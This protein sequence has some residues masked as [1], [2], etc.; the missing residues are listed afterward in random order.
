MTPR[1]SVQMEF[2]TL[3]EWTTFFLVLIYYLLTHSLTHYN[4]PTC[5]LSN[6]ARRVRTPFTQV[7]KM[8][9]LQLV[10]MSASLRQGKSSV[11][12]SMSAA[13]TGADTGNGNG[14][15]SLSSSGWAISAAAAGSGEARAAK[16]IGVIVL[17]FVVSWLPLYTINTRCAAPTSSRH[18]EP[19]VPAALSLCSRYE[20]GVAST[21]TC[22][23][24]CLSFG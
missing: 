22:P 14:G 19:R 11:T 3:T 13:A 8:S 21:S 10:P 17:M 2:D 20:Y 23:F 6:F 15:S 12:W 1:L 7:H 24:R 18:G 4:W 9:G 5:L 16:G